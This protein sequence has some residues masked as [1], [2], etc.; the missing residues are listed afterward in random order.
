MN[1]Y[2]FLLAAGMASTLLFAGCSFGGQVE[3]TKTDAETDIFKQKQ[4]E[5]IE[6]KKQQEAAKQE[7]A[8]AS[9]S[10]STAG[11][12]TQSS[13]SSANTAPSTQQNS[14]ST[15]SSANTGSEPLDGD[16]FTDFKSLTAAMDQWNHS[17]TD[18]FCYYTMTTNEQGKDVYH[19]TRSSKEED[20]A[21]YEE[22]FGNKDKDK[23]K[24][25]DKEDNKDGDQNKETK[26]SDDSS[27]SES[28]DN[29]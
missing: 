21:K 11:S 23:D 1:K 22:L 9:S 15:S 25:K 27:Q 2:K 10:S 5:S 14:Q 13:S 6:K 12:S 17:G 4:A 3:E 8:N 29:K 16:T 26:N 19:L 24:D 18:H 20:P 28:S 7:Q